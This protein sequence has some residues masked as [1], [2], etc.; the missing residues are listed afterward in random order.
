MG[1]VVFVLGRSTSTVAMPIKE[2]EHR[3]QKEQTVGN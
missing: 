2:K 3:V 1:K